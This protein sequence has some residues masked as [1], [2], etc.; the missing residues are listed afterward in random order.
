MKPTVGRIVHYVSRGSADGV[1]PSTDRA[2]MVTDVQ[3]VLDE[4]LNP[5]GEKEVRLTVL[6]PE[7]V[8]YP[9][10]WVREGTAAGC[11]HWPAREA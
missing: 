6:N 2:A 11:W 4:N 10:N 7:G 5:T 3:D 1:Y 8:Y 9:P